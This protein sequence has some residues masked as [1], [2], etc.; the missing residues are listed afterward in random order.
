MTTVA[1]HRE[2]LVEARRREQELV[3]RNAALLA[4]TAE[5][6]RLFEALN[7]VARAAS[8]ELNPIRLADLAVECGRQLLGRVRGVVVLR[9]ETSNRLRIINPSAPHAESETATREGVAAAVLRS[10]EPVVVNDYPGWPDAIT[11]WVENGVTSVVA[12]PL[13]VSGRAIGVMAFCAFEPRQF[14]TRDVEVALMLAAQVAPAIEAARAHEALRESEERYRT[15]LESAIEGAWYVDAE[16]RTIYANRRMAEILRTDVAT[17]MRRTV[18]D[19]TDPDDE[20]AQRRRFASRLNGWSGRADR[21]YLAADGTHVWGSVSTSEIRDQSGAVVGLV[22]LVTDL[23]AQKAAEQALH[24]SEEKSRF[25]AAMSHELRT[26]LNSI[27]GFAQLLEDPRLGRLS[28][29]QRRY[30]DHIRSQ[31]QHLLELINDVLDL[32]KVAAGRLEVKQEEVDV[33]AVVADVAARMQPLAAAKSLELASQASSN[34]SVTADRL[35]L[36]QALVNLAANAVKFTPEGGHVTISAFCRG[37][38]IV[39]SVTDDGPGI[40]AELQPLAFD[41]FSKLSQGRRG[42]GTGLGLALTR[43]LVEAMGGRVTL[44]S[45]VGKGC[46]FT[47]ALPMPDALEEPPARSA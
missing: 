16:G 28:A 20:P 18:W 23:S 42:E 25:L 5:Q 30:L 31:G 22:A 40:P 1:N 21:R 45:Q 15:L 32:S 11:A 2:L 6:A 9:D 38:E 26:P 10:R 8:G 19:F 7:R 41:E 17:L 12:V 14:T 4:E 24:E 27:I 29:R 3:E 13:L 33:A 37:D 43:R 35:R 44:T 46:V 47:V 36:T 39:I 34:I